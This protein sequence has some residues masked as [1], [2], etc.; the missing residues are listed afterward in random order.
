M[1]SNSNRKAT[2]VIRT[3]KFTKAVFDMYM[4]DQ[5]I[6]TGNQQITQGDAMF[7]LVA[8][9]LP[10][11]VDRVKELRPDLWADALMPLEE[12]QS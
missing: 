1:S 3:D 10:D 8:D 5:K 2:E 11:Y 12:G 9:K 7:M 6:K 4:S